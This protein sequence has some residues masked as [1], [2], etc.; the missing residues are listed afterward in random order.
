MARRKG[1]TLIE[2]L[3]VIAIIALL[4]GILM[5]ALNRVKELA[6]CASCKA[7]LRTYTLAV[8]MYAGDNDDRFCDPDLCYFSSSDS[9]P[10]ESAIGADYRHL[11]W[12][13]GD[14]YLRNHPEYGGTLYPYMK[15]A[16]AFI[17]PTY[18]RLT[19]RGSEDQFYRASG[20][21]ITNYRPWYN[22]TMN[23]YLGPISTRRGRALKEY[24][25]ERVTEVENPGETFSFTEESAIVDGN[26]NMSGLN[27]TYMIPGDS[28]MIKKW[29]DQV[30]TNPWYVIPGPEGVGQFYDVI[31]GFHSAPSGDRTGGIGNCAFIDGHVDA[32]PREE[33]FP[34]CWPH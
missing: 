4:M 21:A 22:Y 16:R 20:D 26:Y 1:F 11:R 18:A 15:D 34:L 6:Q 8:Q 17:C 13:N 9:Y 31:A 2:L 28:P 25:V 30:G 12:C 23:A 5:P 32:H 24:R 3:V 33:T 29:F 10:I 27:D 19:I 14:L 7:N